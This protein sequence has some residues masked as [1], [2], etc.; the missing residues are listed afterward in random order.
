MKLNPIK[1]QAQIV[2][3]LKQSPKYGF[4]E[5]GSNVPLNQ[6]GVRL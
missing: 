4:P 2:I 5:N 1:F 3:L 6:H